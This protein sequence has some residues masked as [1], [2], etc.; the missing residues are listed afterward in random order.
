MGREIAC[1]T[2]ALGM[3]V[4]GSVQGATIQWRNSAGQTSWISGA[5]WTNGIEPGAGDVA[6]FMAGTQGVVAQPWLTLSRSVQGVAFNYNAGYP[7]QPGWTLAGA[8]S[9]TLTLGSAGISMGGTATLS[10]AGAAT[11]QA[12]INTIGLSLGVDQTW[13]INNTT[14]AQMAFTEL[15]VNS[16]IHGDASLTKAGAGTLQLRGANTWTGSTTVIGGLLSL[17]GGSGSIASSAG[18]MVQSAGLRLDSSG[19]PASNNHN[20]R[21]KGDLTL[22]R[23]LL[24]LMG[25]GSAATPTDTAEAID[26]LH[27]AGGHNTIVLARGTAAQRTTLSAGRLTR[28]AAGRATLLVRTNDTQILGNGGAG[29]TGLIVDG[30]GGQDAFSLDD[31][32]GTT[33]VRDGSGAG[34]K[35]IRI[36]PWAIGSAGVTQAGNNPLAFNASHGDTWLTYDAGADDAIGGA[37]DRGFRM[38]DLATE[39]ENALVEGANVRLVATG[40]SSGHVGTTINSL[41]LHNGRT[42]ASAVSFSGS[43]TLRIASGAILNSGHHAAAGATSVR[44]TRLE[45]FDAIDLG[46]GDGVIHVT[47][48]TLNTS[49]MT[50]A[51]FAPGTLTIDSP[52]HAGGALVKSG[53][54]TLVL[55]RT[56]TN[57]GQ[58]VFVVDGTLGVAVPNAFGAAVP[59]SISDGATFDLRG[60]DQRF[61]AITGPGTIRNSAVA[62]AALT[63]GSNATQA[64]DATI[65]DG[66]G[67]VGLVKQ[68]AG[69][70]VL[71][72]ANTFSGGL[73]I[74]GGIVRLDAS[75][76]IGA[77]NVITL[78]NAA[79]AVFDLAGHRQTVGGLAGG[80][81]VGGEVQLGAGTLAVNTSAGTSTQFEGTISGV[82]GALVKAGPG[83]L[84]LD[85]R[86]TY[87]GGTTV[88]GGTL[89]LGNTHALGSG[90]VTIN[91][92]G[93]AIFSVFTDASGAPALP[94]TL[95]S[96]ATFGGSGPL[97]FGTLELKGGTHTLTVSNPVTRVSAIVHDGTA[98]RAFTKQGGG[99]LI[100]DGPITYTGATTIGG[101]T[102]AIAGSMPATTGTITLGPG[103]IFATSGTFSRAVGTGNNTINWNAAA[104]AGFAAYGT[105]ETWESN[106]LLVDLSTPSIRWGSTSGFVTASRSLVLGSPVANGMVTFKNALHLGDGTRDVY[107][108]RAALAPDGAADA[109]MSG[110]LTFGTLSKSGPGV[111]ELT[112]ANLHSNTLVRAGTLLVNNTTGS[113]TG[114]GT[115]TVDAG[116]TLG[117]G[118]FI[119][120]AT[121]VSGTLAPG[122]SPGVLTVKN[123]V[124]L[125]AGS[126]MH[127]EIAGRS[128]GTEYDQL[129][130]DHPGGAGLT[131]GEEVNLRLSLLDGFVPVVG[132]RFVIVLSNAD[133]VAGVFGRLNGV[134]ADLSDG[135][136]FAFAGLQWRIDYDAQSD[137]TPHGG[138]NVVLAVVPEPDALAVALPMAVLLR[139]RRCRT[140]RQG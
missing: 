76:R 123:A 98:S 21:I 136:P 72:S 10:T 92:S 26:A 29:G 67:P 135:A 115:V 112:G 129:V 17:S 12:T 14:G 133:P 110:Q 55:T 18:I 125:N 54:G 100:V 71:K 74:H 60:A 15:L 94:V 116:A 96:S 111:L 83:T 127:I 78:G 126:E 40:S 137:G 138:R 88:S 79:G 6:T 36:L 43:G 91:G 53:P 90:P 124:T 134:A 120:G 32:R 19:T 27:L 77:G 42:D 22:R 104:D 75:D 95:A 2:A 108:H 34:A 56:V 28:A 118:G 1:L 35:D 3:G 103:A 65:T 47:A 128:V 37:P 4:A 5:S 70:L 101:G 46:P 97:K 122:N 106:H 107:V 80:G 85:G 117:G 44:N 105:G 84:R 82:G 16:V 50:G 99:A 58:G 30:T 119:G 20:D 52:L 25:N 31:L 131:I 49:V 89:L 73:T 9:A 51:A 86:N 8:A 24:H 121:H 69:T 109:R 132:D 114:V 102:L 13:T 61:T 81:D 64:L 41:I 93:S 33:A 23:G 38:L 59:L 39:Y 68:G 66:I 62:A 11:Y 87:T 7:G 140:S 63:I 45:G 48:G 57:G 113:A 130:I 139:R